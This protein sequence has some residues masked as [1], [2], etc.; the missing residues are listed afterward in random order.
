[1]VIET[2]DRGPAFNPLTA[3]PPKVNLDSDDLAFSGVGIFLTRHYVDDLS[4]AREGDENVFRMTKILSPK[5]NAIQ[6]TTH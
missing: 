1:L 4:Y 6:L 2:R 3:P 5:L